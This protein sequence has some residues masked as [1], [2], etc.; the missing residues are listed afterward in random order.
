MK[1]EVNSRVLS[2]RWFGAGVVV[3]AKEQAHYP[4]IVRWDDGSRS[5]HMECDLEAE[6]EISPGASTVIARLTRK[7]YA[8]LR[9][10]PPAKPT[11]EDLTRGICTLV[12][13][14]TGITVPGKVHMD[15]DSP[16]PELGV[17]WLKPL[18]DSVAE[19]LGREPARNPAVNDLREVVL[20]LRTAYRTELTRTGDVAGDVNHRATF[21]LISQAVNAGYAAERRRRIEL[22][23]ELGRKDTDL[24][25]TVKQLQE[26]KR[27]YVSREMYKITLDERN[28]WCAR[29][30]KAEEKL[31][32]IQ[33]AMTK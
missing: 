11:L 8:G 20:D 15:D 19:M 9:W 29:A 4:Y 3:E 12:E 1:F 7:V 2:R 18:Y 26:T 23:G 22:E 10:T 25:N 17:S 31:A 27:E 24:R 32:A 30:E 5:P 21:N 14:L 28:A 6:P 33:A 13:V 16:Q